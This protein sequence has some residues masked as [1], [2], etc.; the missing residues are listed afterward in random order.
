[1]RSFTFV[2]LLVGAAVALPQDSPA[3]VTTTDTVF[4]PTTTITYT[5]T[6]VQ[7]FTATTPYYGTYTDYTT[8]SSTTTVNTITT[9]STDC[10]ASGTITAQPSTTVYTTAG[11]PP[12]YKRALGLAPRQDSACTVTETTTSYSGEAYSFPAASETS[13]YTQYTDYLQSTVYET[14]T[15]GKAYTV[16]TATTT[17]CT[18]CGPTVSATA[19][20][21]AATAT[22]DARCAPSSLRSAAGGTDNG[23]FG[24]QFIGTITGAVYSQN[25]TT[26]SDCCQ[27][28]VDAGNC[29]V[30][31]WDVQTGVCR[32]EFTA[33]YSTGKVNC[34]NQLVIA[35]Y[36]AGP[37]RPMAPGSGLF[38][39]DLC[40]TVGYFSAK[41]DDGT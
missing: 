7:A 16:A 32:L 23:Q 3:C 20:T 4:I 37:S 9:T 18:A 6:P 21:S 26:A 22:L 30:S 14:S 36:D 12:S 5:T 17:L 1:M 39:G 10:T 13:Y 33:D 29:A 35:Y 19:S 15:G 2:P 25:T 41:P 40:G 24:I 38:V 34:G 31:A 11:A 8:I 27:L 28:C